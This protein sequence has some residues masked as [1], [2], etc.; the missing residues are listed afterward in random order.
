MRESQDL[1]QHVSMPAAQRSSL[2]GDFTANGP[3]LQNVRRGLGIGSPAPSA[4]WIDFRGYG[5]G[6]GGLVLERN[7]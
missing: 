6:V 2:T 1:C 7:G 3:M 5:W 4:R